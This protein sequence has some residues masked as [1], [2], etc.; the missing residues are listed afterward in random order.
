MPVFA[1]ERMLHIA[2]HWRRGAVR[3]RAIEPRTR[4]SVTGAQRLQP[5]LRCFLEIVD[6]GG[7]R[8]LLSSS[9]GVRLIRAE[10]R[11][12][13]DRTNLVGGRNSLAA[14]RRRPSARWG[15]FYRLRRTS[16]F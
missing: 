14:D 6:R 10:R 12:A 15:S 11:F 7:H 16:D 8:D 5:T 3:P 9:P 1:R 13:I 4:V 2:Q